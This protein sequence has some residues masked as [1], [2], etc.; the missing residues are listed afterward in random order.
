MTRVITVVGIAYA[1]V[2]LSILL[3]QS[4]GAGLFGAIIA[5]GC[6]AANQKGGAA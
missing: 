1:T 5:V 4:E 6:Y 3:G 2:G